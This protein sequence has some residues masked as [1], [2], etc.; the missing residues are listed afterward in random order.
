[1]RGIVGEDLLRVEFFLR[2][3]VKVEE[4]NLNDMTIHAGQNNLG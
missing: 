1:M 4:I 3:G 2:E